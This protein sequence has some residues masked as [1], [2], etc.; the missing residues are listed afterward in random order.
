MFWMKMK[1]KVFFS[2]NLSFPLFCPSQQYRVAY[3]YLLKVTGMLQI[4]FV[5]LWGGSK[6]RVGWLTNDQNNPQQL[7]S[8][9]KW[10][11]VRKGSY[12]GPETRPLTED[13]QC[14][15]QVMMRE[16]GRTYS[17][18]GIQAHR[19]AEVGITVVDQTQPMHP[20]QKNDCLPTSFHF[21]IIQKILTGWAWFKLIVDVRS[22]PFYVKVGTYLTFYSNTLS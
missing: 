19:G 11:E 16:V 2:L 10:K 7:P 5:H 6:W 13:S 15:H 18:G 1:Y 4:Q 14:N 3:P 8:F 9:T 12:L 21:S 17:L 22:L 20:E